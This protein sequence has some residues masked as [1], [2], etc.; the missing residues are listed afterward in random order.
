M[1]QIIQMKWA[2][3]FQ[4]VGPSDYVKVFILDRYLK[5]DDYNV[6]LGLFNICSL[7]RVS[8]NIS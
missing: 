5:K 1:K 2:L 3:P 7:V 8:S 4:K 6:G